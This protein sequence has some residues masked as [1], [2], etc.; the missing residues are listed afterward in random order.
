M[1]SNADSAVEPKVED[2]SVGPELAETETKPATEPMDGDKAA[3]SEEGQATDKTDAPSAAP[4]RYIST[5]R[6]SEHAV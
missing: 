2:A 6:V 1:S 4:V 3:E 5:L